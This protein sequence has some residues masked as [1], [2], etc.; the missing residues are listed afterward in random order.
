MHNQRKTFFSGLIAILLGSSCCW[1]STMAV[2]AGGVGL[3]GVLANYT[4][5]I[6]VLLL[7][8]GFT[9]ILIASYKFIKT[10]KK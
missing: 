3:L 10:N 5:K 8:V 7:L 9:L 4:E 1:L 2:W 6:Q